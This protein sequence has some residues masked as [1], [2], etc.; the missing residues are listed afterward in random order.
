MKL[1]T[2][3]QGP[4]LPGST[5]PSHGEHLGSISFSQDEHGMGCVACSGVVYIR[6]LGG[7][8]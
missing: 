7:P 2:S 5:E 8:S 3:K 6:E 1:R 4:H